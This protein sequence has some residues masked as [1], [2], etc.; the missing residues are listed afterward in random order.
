MA[1][2][3]VEAEAGP[4]ATG[5]GVEAR[6]PLSAQVRHKRD[7]SRAR[8]HHEGLLVDILPGD[9]QY[10]AYPLQGEARVLDRRHRVPEPWYSSP[11]Q[12]GATLRVGFGRSL[13][14]HD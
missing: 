8:R 14:R 13:R 3:V 12:V 6:R 11:V 10:F 1:A 2:R 7:A 5:A 9:A 4:G